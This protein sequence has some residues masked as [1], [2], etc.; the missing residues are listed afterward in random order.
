VRAEVSEP[1]ADTRGTGRVLQFVDVHSDSAASDYELDEPLGYHDYDQW[2]ASYR[3]TATLRLRRILRYKPPPGRL[4]EI[5]TATGSFLD[6]ARRCGFSVR[7][8][9]LSQTFADVARSR[10]G[11]DIEGGFIE[12][13]TLPQGHYD[14]VCAFGGIACWR[15]PVRGLRNIHRSLAPRGIFV[16]N[17]PDIDGVLGRL[18]GGR[19]PEFNHA[20]LTIFSTGTM[21]RCLEAAGFEMVF[22]ENERQYTSIDRI[23]TYLRSGVGRRIVDR[24]GL[25]PLTIPVIAFGTISGVCV[26]ARP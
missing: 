7:G 3:E 16:L 22:A 5:G 25:N 2:D 10:Y 21:K 9:D 12:E 18:L 14:V 6:A 13:A 4:L 20:S 23:V 1:Q 8:L 19:Y 17:Y 15:D 26:P 24:F 11:L